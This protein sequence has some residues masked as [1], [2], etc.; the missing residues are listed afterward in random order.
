MMKILDLIVDNHCDVSETLS[1][2]ALGG[3][4]KSDSDARYV[5]SA[6]HPFVG[7]IGGMDQINILGDGNKSRIEEEVYRLFDV[8]G[9]SGGYICSASDHFFNVT[10]ENLECFAQAAKACR[11]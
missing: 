10:S 9:S 8:F 5:K 4:I 1:P 6:L 3:D 11:Y 7:M 2:Q